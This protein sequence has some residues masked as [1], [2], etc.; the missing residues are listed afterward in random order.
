[1]AKL[2]LAKDGV[3][4]LKDDT[5]NPA[6]GLSV[7]GTIQGEGKLAGVPS[8]FVRLAGCNLR[9]I[10][11]MNDGNLSRCD[12]PYASFSPSET[13]EWEVSDIVYQIKT[14]ASNLNHLVITG[15]EPLLQKDAVAE[16]C[17]QVK[18]ELG[19]HITIESNGTLFDKDVAENADLYSISPKLSNS[20]P[21]K[22]K[23]DAFNI[24]E[25]KQQFYDAK[26]R[27]NLSAI[28]SYIDAKKHFPNKDLQI[29]FVATSTKDE[30]EIKNDYLSLL[31]GFAP[32]DIMLMPLGRNEDE[33][34]LSEAG[35]LE[36]AIRN[37][38]WFSQRLHIHFFGE[39]SGV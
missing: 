2:I 39:K 24:S 18:A 22:Q 11:K 31:N 17:K 30:S 38:W 8:L 35:V 6:T 9:C 14:H 36:M 27:R 15:G 19:W 5:Q 23:Y 25:E 4:P 12:T 32:N 13:M 3:F 37:G 28:Q 34:A 10:W 16:L 20:E 29:K 7:S 1:M 26:K 33:L 21:D